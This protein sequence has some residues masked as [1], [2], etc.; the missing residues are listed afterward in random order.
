MTVLTKSNAWNREIL[1]VGGGLAGALCA[2]AIKRLNPEVSLLILEQGRHFGG[3]HR[4]SYFDSDLEDR[5]HRLVEGI[6]KC[7]WPRYEVQFPNRH[8][9]IETGYNSFCSK[10]L[11]LWLQQELAP[12]EYRLT[13]IAEVVT[14]VS[15]RLANG[16]IL[17]ADRVIDARGP[18]AITGLEVAWQKFA[19]F[20]LEV[21][22]NG[23]KH[24]IIMDAC[25]NQSD[26][27]RFMYVIPLPLD[28]LFVEDTYYSL[29]PEIDVDH[30]RRNV[31]EYVRQY[32]SIGTETSVET[33]S[34]PI[35]LS[36]S[37]DRFWPRDDNVARMG[38]R[39]GFFHHTT[40]Y[41]LPLAIE[42]AL[43][44][45][46]LWAAGMRPDAG[47]WRE[48]FTRSWQRQ[49]YFRLLNRMLFHGIEP[50]DRYRILEHFYRLPQEVIER[51]YNRDLSSL[52]KLRVLT[53]KPPLSIGKAIKASIRRSR[54]P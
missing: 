22:G 34:L 9:I 36:G 50:I 1:I 4:W 27:Y 46:D 7:R 19:G 5:G 33:G 26:G 44:F 25:V 47:W 31:R 11:D 53:G 2:V 45:A 10:A 43:A 21:P 28:L 42:N 51:F 37:P 30:L 39:G 32:G 29:H 6:E 35:A 15:A 16:E 23:L 41:S 40:G 20:E 17:Y 49:S 54:Q 18:Q 52:D 8:R 24:P 48:R 13:T 3:N 12:S 38:I 14:P